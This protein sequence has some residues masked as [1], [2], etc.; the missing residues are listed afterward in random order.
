MPGVWTKYISGFCEWKGP[1][2]TPPP[3]GPRSTNAEHSRISFHLL[4][5][6]LPDCL[7]ICCRCHIRFFST[8]HDQPGQV[9]LIKAE[10]DQF[11]V[12]CS[13]GSAGAK[14]QINKA[15]SAQLKLCP[16]TN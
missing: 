4:P 8:I 13:P 12:G 11:R 14:A 2:W 9:T 15:R 1:P 7:K 10:S 5:Q 16:D 6:S 3:A